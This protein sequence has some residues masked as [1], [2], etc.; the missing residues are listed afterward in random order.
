[1]YFG[2]LGAP[3]FRSESEARA[4]LTK[5]QDVV[6]SIEN[7]IR[8]LQSRGAGAAKITEAN[9]K[10]VKAKSERDRLA[11]VVQKFDARGDSALQDVK[12]YE[13]QADARQKLLTKALVDEIKTRKTQHKKIAILLSEIRGDRDKVRSNLF[14]ADK[15]RYGVKRA[16]ENRLKRYSKAY[17]EAKQRGSQIKRMGALSK[18]TRSLMVGHIK[19][20]VEFFEA[21]IKLD[22]QE[23]GT[24]K[25]AAKTGNKVATS[26]PAALPKY[27]A[28]LLPATK[29]TLALSPGATL[30]SDAELQYLYQL[31]AASVPKRKGESDISY[32]MRVRR[33][34]YRVAVRMANIRHKYAKEK[35]RF[36]QKKLAQ[37]SVRETLVTDQ[38]AIEHEHK[39]NV[40]APAGEQVAVAA[41]DAATGVRAAPVAK[42]AFVASAPA[43]AAQY[44]VP[45]S[46]SVVPASQVS[47]SVAKAAAA[48]TPSTDEDGEADE[49]IAAATAAEDTSKETEKAEE[50]AASEEGGEAATPIWRRPLFWVAV[51][52]IGFL[53][54]KSMS[55]DQAKTETATE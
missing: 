43:A 18:E 49:S 27:Q 29:R 41:V 17:K 3:I 44:S 36:D 24:I 9:T 22:Q 45:V 47:P 42:A 50:K 28:N 35:K 51:G 46:P 40:Y 16:L 48:Q 34:T 19:E 31:T 52:A 53:G 37:A 11:K 12:D 1:M 13:K 5:A 20:N 21:N 7:G 38:T 8:V 23:L 39:T 33:Y 14:E 25:A 2:F 30:P 26:S 6:D 32:E 55:G 54:Y 15:A 4:A 10:L